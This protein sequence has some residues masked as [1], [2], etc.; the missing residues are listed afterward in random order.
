M[1]FPISLHTLFLTF[2]FVFVI[3][4]WFF[5]F[6]VVFF[7]LFSE[8]E[9]TETIETVKTTTEKSS[10]LRKVS[11]AS[12]VVAA[13]STTTTTTTTAT[14]SSSSSSTATDPKA[15]SQ[16]ST[17][18]IKAS[19]SQNTSTNN[20]NNNNN[21][22]N[23]TTN[24]NNEEPQPGL[25]DSVIVTDR[26]GNQRLV[27]SE[28]SLLDGLQRAEFLGDILSRIRE[29]HYATV[30]E[31]TEEIQLLRGLLAAEIGEEPNAKIGSSSS[32]RGVAM[33][34]NRRFVPPKTENGKEEEEEEKKKKEKTDG[35]EEEGATTDE[36]RHE[37]RRLHVRLSS[38][39]LQRERVRH[40]LHET[41]S[42][43]DGMRSSQG[44]VASLLGVD[45]VQ[46]IQQQQQQSLTEETSSMSLEFVQQFLQ[47]LART[48]P[49]NADSNSN[50][51]VRELFQNLPAPWPSAFESLARQ[52]QDAQ[53]HAAR[54]HD[55]LRTLRV[56]LVEQ[57]RKVLSQAAMV[58]S[59]LVQRAVGEGVAQVHEETSRYVVS[60]YVLCLCVFVLC[61]FVLCLFI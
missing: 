40:S 4:F 11:S 41:Q 36:L 48:S 25:D 20:N 46:L 53:D 56:A 55:E 54:T 22:N 35:E 10:G 9:T 16:A 44:S 14:S 3:F 58:A 59:V 45:G 26:S 37:I 39:L 18:S 52:L 30:K 29:E 34:M 7:V 5:F 6:R 23:T 51:D 19:D 38:V 17:K 21:N 28:R 47:T 1:L 12:E 8:K 49:D 42:M 32:S 31:L 61:V 60:V 24:N 50:S 33:K 43:L 13:S 2:C 57:Q 27:V 15:V